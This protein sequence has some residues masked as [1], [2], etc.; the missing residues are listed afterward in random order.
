MKTWILVWFLIHPANDDGTV[1]WEAG[2]SEPMTE[3]ECNSRLAQEDL[4]YLLMEKNGELAGHTL[5]CRDTRGK[6]VPITRI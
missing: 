3:Q 1:E 4:D 2:I 5:Y 6:P